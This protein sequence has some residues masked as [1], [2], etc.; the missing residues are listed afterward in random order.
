MKF[1]TLTDPA[2][3]LQLLTGDDWGPWLIEA[4][5]GARASIHFSI[6]MVSHHWRIPN[7]FKLDLLET[8][9]KCAQ[10]GLRCRGL[11]AASESIQSRTPFNQGAAEALTA[12][13]WKIRMMPNPHLLHE[14]V[15]LLDR[16]TVVIGSHNISR[17][18]LTTNHD[19][20]IAVTSPDLAAQ[21]YRLFWERW[22]AAESF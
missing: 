14:K 4:L 17:A 8:L 18:S 20:S 5:K 7:R 21:V 6:Y 3:T 22:R 13:G 10:R 9:A 1:E 11:L 2:A 16:R 15:I 19:T 12:A